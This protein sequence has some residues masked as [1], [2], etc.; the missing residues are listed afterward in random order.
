MPMF[1]PMDVTAQG[2][3]IADSRNTPMHVG[4]LQ[5]F[6]P[7][8]G[9]GPEWSRKYY[10][11]AL[12]VP[13]TAPLY[14]KR[15]VRKVRT[16][17]TWWW[18]EDDE[19]DLEYHARH[20][21]LPSPGRV[22]ELLEVLGRLHGTRMAFE[23]PLW[24]MN[25][26]EG[27]EDGRFAIYSKLHHALVD[28]I[29]A[30]WL[31]QATISPDPDHRETPPPWAAPTL[32][33]KVE[34][35]RAA[36]VERLASLPVTAV[37]TAWAVSAEAAGLPGALIRTL[38]R[39]VRNETA[40]VALYAPRTIL[41]R[42]ITGARRF[43][44][45]HWPIDRLKQVGKASGATINDVVLAMCGGALRKYLLDLGSLPDQP[46]VAM[47]PVSLRTARGTT[48]DARGG[49]AV[50]TL[51]VKLG[52]DETDPGRRLEQI[53]AS[54]RSGKDALAQMTPG[55]VPPWWC[56]CCGSTGSCARRTTW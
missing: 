10:D 35:E 8:E 22:R 18:T 32:T 25:Y 31:L 40:P 11:W 51:M 44:A 7:P 17:G 23:R 42:N 13:A 37:R 9:E 4:G 36:L 20:T 12:Q 45:Q 27:M 3:M 5:L 15:P 46:L 50:G 54:V 55:S 47:V 41:N 2:F 29:A 52:T 19:F 24:E 53:S 28:G 56:R 33:N 14:L 49:N 6:E 26:I 21:A 34:R 16:G 1:T 48:A 39:A 38:N 30:M 43:A